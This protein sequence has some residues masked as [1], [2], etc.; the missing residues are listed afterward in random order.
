VTLRPITMGTR[1]SALPPT[2][3]LPER[4]DSRVRCLLTGPR[5]DA[6]GIYPHGTGLTSITTHSSVI[7]VPAGVMVPLTRRVLLHRCT[8]ASLGCAVVLCARTTL[9]TLHHT[10]LSIEAFLQ[11]RGFHPRRGT[12]SGMPSLTTTNAGCV[13]GYLYWAASLPRSV[14]CPTLSDG[15]RGA[16]PPILCARHPAI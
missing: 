14:C 8:L 5:R 4:G 11:R 13:R 3:A 2:D 9:G 7:E 6:V 15:V 12:D 1:L 16:F 10:L